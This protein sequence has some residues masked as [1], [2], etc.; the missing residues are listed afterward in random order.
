[1]RYSRNPRGFKKFIVEFITTDPEQI[2]RA[3][4]I[5][6]RWRAHSVRRHESGVRAVFPD[7][8]DHDYALDEARGWGIP[9]GSGVKKNP[10]SSRTKSR[11]AALLAEYRYEDAAKVYK[12]AMQREKRKRNPSQGYGGHPKPKFKVG[13]RVSDLDGERPGVIDHIGSYQG[14]S[15]G[16]WAYKVQEDNGPRTFR[17]E[18]GLMRVKRRKNPLTA[19]LGGTYIVTHA[20]PRTPSTSV[21]LRFSS[22]SDAWEGMR[23]LDDAGIAAGYPSL[24]PESSGPHKGYYT[25]RVSRK[26]AAA[27]QKVLSG[28]VRTNPQP[29]VWECVTLSN[30]MGTRVV[31]RS[32]PY[33]IEDKASGTAAIRSKDAPNRFV[34]FDAN[35]RGRSRSFPTLSEAKAAVE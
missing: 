15:Y 1:M 34:L 20:N 29:R 13:D 28:G 17:L 33:Q 4:K 35:V 2:K 25:V 16:G 31:Y 26:N 19:G 12:R 9:T 10:I 18:S 11:H 3:K 22:R 8:M 5:A 21:K 27:A 30:S 7:K 24:G 14:A 23:T 32:G 6:E